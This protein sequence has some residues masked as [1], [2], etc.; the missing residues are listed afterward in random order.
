MKSGKDFDLSFAY[1][2]YAFLKSM[3][4]HK[5]QQRTLKMH[6]RGESHEAASVETVALFYP[7]A[8]F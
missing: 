3:E 8:L 2:R 4:K 5:E 7:L 6:L 1:S